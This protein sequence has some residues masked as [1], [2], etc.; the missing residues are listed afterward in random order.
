MAI[1]FEL[2]RDPD[3]LQQYYELRER[4]YRHELKLAGFDGSEEPRDR[5]S[6]VLLAQRDGRCLGGARIALPEQSL[7]RLVAPAPLRLAD[8]SLAATGLREM[9]QQGRRPLPRQYCTWERL[10]L[11]P[12][13]RDVALA[14]EFCYRLIETSTHMGYS[15]ALILSSLR[16]ARFYRQCHSH[17]GIGY[18][19]RGALPDAAVGAFTALEHYLSVSRMPARLAPLQ[20]AA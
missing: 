18:E 1:S 10:A 14:R 4:C 7:M 5:D 11:D 6:V 3:L 16:N 9:R 19:I 8:S 20:L 12:E 2:S 17:L 15:H 13:R